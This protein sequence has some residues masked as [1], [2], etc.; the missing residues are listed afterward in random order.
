MSIKKLL[1]VLFIICISITTMAQKQ[2]VINV[3][4]DSYVANHRAPKEETWHY[5]MA[6]AMGMKYNNYGRN[7]ASMAFDRTHDGQYNFGPAIY[8]KAK[9]MDAAADYVL[10]IAGHNDAEKIKNNADSLKMFRDSLTLF[11]KNIHE[12]CPKAKIG[13]VT[14]W[15]VERPGFK[16]VCNMI[17]KVCKKNDIPVL[18]NYSPDCI[19]KVRD[20]D[21]RKKYFQGPK[22]TAHLNKYGHDLFLPIGTQWF[23]TYMKKK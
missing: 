15:Y 1:T 12:Q 10:I 20:D 3:I 22:D 14:P 7:G 17:K 6:Q 18:F 21:F 23:N 5:K 4:G 2:E 9:L 8:T 19:I 11:I 16:E 13:Y